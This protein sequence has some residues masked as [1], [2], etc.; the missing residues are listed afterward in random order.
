MRVSGN[1]FKELF[2]RKTDTIILPDDAVLSP[3][4]LDDD[5]SSLSAILLDTDYY[6]LLKEGKTRVNGVTVL[7]APYLILFKAKAW[8]DLSDRKK[9]GEQVDSKNIRKHKNDVFRLT[10]LLDHNQ[11]IPF[12]IPGAVLSDI[13]EFTERMRSEDI[14]LKQLGIRGKTKDEILDELQRLYG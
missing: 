7:D 5:V 4:P 11:E 3:L 10:E 6:D 13:R 9:A 12:H 2:A 14:D 1:G 8:L